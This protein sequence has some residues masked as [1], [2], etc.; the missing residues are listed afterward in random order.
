MTTAA[1]IGCGDV[2][3]VHLEAIEAVGS[4]LV[5]VC[6]TDPEVL[7]AAVE[8]CGVPGFADH[9]A[10]L[11]QVRPDVAHICTPHHQHVPV[12]LDLLD[13]GVHVL[14]EKPLAHTLA[15]AERLVAAAERNPA[16]IGVCFQNRYNATAQA[17]RELLDSGELG[18]VLGA[19]ATVLWTRTPDYYLA[20]PWRGR[21]ATA[22]GGL[23]I[24][25]AIH[26]LDL[27]QWLVG[28]VVDVRGRAATRLHGDVIEVEDTAELLL[29]HDGGARSVVFGSLA[30]V[31][32]APVTIDITAERGSLSLRGDLTTTHADGRVETVRERR[33]PSNGRAYWGASH[34]ALIRDFH[35]RLGEDEPFWISPREAMKSLRVLTDVYAQS[36]LGVD[37]MTTVG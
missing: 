35:A 9:R 1:V 12:A 7:A 22:G 31:V 18:A 3:T 15:A 13:A 19:T 8:R 20:K 17:A 28:D 32:H 25:Q 33:A 26:T 14:V 6:D 30:N 5:A 4:E 23:L 36:G 10:L 34:E 27:V 24:N 29:T 11:A 21:W 2:S 16:R 37:R